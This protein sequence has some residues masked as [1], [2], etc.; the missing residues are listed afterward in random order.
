MLLAV[1]AWL[2]VTVLPSILVTVVLY[3]IPVPNTCHPAFIILFLELS[4]KTNLVELVPF[5]L[6]LTS[7][8]P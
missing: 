7:L 2:S 1:A 8:L 6:P 3:G 5:E 4:F